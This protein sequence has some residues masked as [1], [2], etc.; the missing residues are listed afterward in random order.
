MPAHRKYQWELWFGQPV[1]QLVRGLDYKCSQAIMWQTVRNNARQR[2][3]KA[4]VTDTHGG[5]LIEV[6]SEI[7]H[8]DTSA[9]VEQRAHVLE[10]D[11]QDQEAAQEGDETLHAG[12][13]SVDTT[14]SPSRHHNAHRPAKVR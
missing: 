14:T 1:T 12:G 4:R 3:V 5:I 10:E 13:Y 9:V 11:V 2:G 7:P 8:P 6:L